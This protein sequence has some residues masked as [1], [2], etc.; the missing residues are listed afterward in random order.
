MRLGRWILVGCLALGLGLAA[1]GRKP[2][3]VDPPSG[4]DAPRFPRTYPSE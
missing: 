4:D 1:C 2:N 3:A